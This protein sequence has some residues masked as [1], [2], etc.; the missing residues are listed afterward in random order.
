MKKLFATLILLCAVISVSFAQPR[1]I[2]GRIGY[3]VEASYQHSIAKINMLDISAGVT[4]EW[5]GWAYAEA[6][7]M[8]DWVFNIKGG[9]N[10]YVGPG[11]GLGLGYGRFWN[12]HNYNPFR[13]NVGAQLGFE[14][15][16]G[17]PLNL[18]IDWRPMVN[19]LGFGHNAYPI[20]KSFYNF[21]I[22]VRYRFH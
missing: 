11:V 19:V 9:W 2:G 12:E 6:N 3:N 20:Y 15:Q 8:F 1:A 10:W 21:A 16:F 13:V 4:N 17:I 7:C 18:S 22:G 14:Y 5:N